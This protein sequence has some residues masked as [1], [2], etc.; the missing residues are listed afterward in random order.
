MKVDSG[1]AAAQTVGGGLVSSLTASGGVRIDGAMGQNAGGINGIYEATTEL[2]DDMPVYAKTGNG[3]VWLE[4]RADSKQWQVKPTAAKGTDGCTA[5]CAVPA[6]CLPEDC[7]PGQWNLYDCTKWGPQPAVTISVVTQ[8]EVEAHLE[9]VEREASR[10]VNISHNVCIAGATGPNAGLIN[11]VYKPSEE[12]CDNATVYVK[13]NDGNMWLE[14]HADLKQWQVKSTAYKSTDSSCAFCAVPAK[15][16][17]EDCPAGQWKV[18]D[19]TKYAPQP[20]VTISVQDDNN[21][22]ASADD[23]DDDEAK[24]KAAAMKVDLG[25]VAAQTTGRGLVSSAASGGV[26]IVGAM[27]PNA[28]RIN[29]IYEATPEMSGS[30]PVYAKVGCR[31]MWLEYRVMSWQ[32]KPTSQKGKDG[33]FA[34]CA[35]P[36]KC[37]PE[38]CPPGQWQLSDGGK[39][40]LRPTIVISVVTQEEVE[41]HLEQ[42]EREAA[43]VV[44]GSQ[45]VRIA[46]ATGPKADYVNGN[47]KPTEEKCDNATVYVKVDDGSWWLEYHTSMKQWQVKPTAI[48]GTSSCTAYCA[49]AAKCLPEDC[50]P[51]Q[52]IV[53]DGTKLDPQSAVTIAVQH[54]NNDDASANDVDDDEAKPKAAAMKVAAGSATAQATGVGIASP[55]A[56][57]I[58]VVTQEEAEAHEVEREGSRVVNGSHNVYIAGAMGS[59]AGRI[60][61]VYKPTKELCD[62]ATV[63]VN[64]NDGT[65]WLEYHADLKQWQVKPTSGKGLRLCTAYCTVPVKC[66][67]EDCPPGQWLVADGTKWGPQQN[68]AISIQHD[69]NDAVIADDVDDDEAKPKA[70]A[71]KVAAGLAAAQTAGVGI[72]SPT[73]SGGIR[74]DG[75]HNVRIAGAT[76]PNAGLINGMYK[77]T[78]EKCENATVYVK[79][80]DGKMWL[81]YYAAALKQWQVKSTTSKGTSRCTMYCTV[82]SKCLPED[83]PP[84][85]WKVYDGTKYAPQSAV[86]IAVQHDNGD[87]ASADDDDDDEASRRRRR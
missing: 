11:G 56:V 6:K 57:T 86:T 43:R 81:E 82:P 83:C 61:G 27:G 26:R 73:T 74:I 48:K 50:P 31:D 16:L 54:D 4:Y 19:G 53:W 72:A 20:E 85:Q 24:P 33:G 40:V 62:N 21:C 47:Y 42:V 9:Q 32:V 49:V 68:V 7:P 69:N 17:P 12:L 77:P 3:D 67:P 58:S 34:L 87:A 59:N 46:G 37:L 39:L 28:G 52:W 84:G 64:V 18:Y 15:C 75:S 79:L 70:A 71:M 78:E 41:A 35:V 22:A 10:V 14:Y 45:N 63:Y 80:G 13:V 66:L 25:P 55:T 60:N 51:G 1:L 23:G 8:E 38:K 44:N 65:M 76:G 2:S 30:M 29:G 36:A 5:Y